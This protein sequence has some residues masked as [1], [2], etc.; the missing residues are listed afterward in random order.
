[1]RGGFLKKLLAC[2]K[3]ALAQNAEELVIVLEI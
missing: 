2:G 3:R 1:M